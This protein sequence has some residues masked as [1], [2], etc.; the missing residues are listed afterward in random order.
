[1]HI[2]RIVNIGKD[3]EKM[4]SLF[5][6]VCYLSTYVNCCIYLHLFVLTY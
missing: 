6:I 3:N 2:M 4:K 1:M 5:T